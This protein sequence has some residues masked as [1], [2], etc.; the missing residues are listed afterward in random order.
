MAIGPF[1][2]YHNG[3]KNVFNGNIDFLTDTMKA[4]ILLS[5]YTP[6]QDTHDA[7]DDVS[8]HE[9]A[10]G[11]YAKKTLASKAVSI[12]DGAIAIDAADIDFGSSV[13]I[14]GKYL[15]IFKDSGTPSTSY[16]LGYIDLDETGGGSASSVAAPFQVLFGPDGIVGVVP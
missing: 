10:D 1:R 13:T 15:A 16:L 2:F 3:L 4:A 14:T 8:S 7:W 9:C 12:V 11:D 5:T 6:A